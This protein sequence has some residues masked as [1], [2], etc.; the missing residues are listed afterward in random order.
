MSQHNLENATIDVN[1]EEGVHRI[2]TV[3][4]PNLVLDDEITVVSSQNLLILTLSG[5]DT[6]TFVGPCDMV[7]FAQTKGVPALKR[8][9]RTELDDQNVN[10]M[11]DKLDF[12]IALYSRVEKPR[13]TFPVSTLK[14][15]TKRRVNT[16]K[17]VS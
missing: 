8:Y 16:L 11:L 9:L 6:L 2:F 12:A 5:G 4:T 15:Q 13:A 1:I 7:N 14:R 17:S 3:C 10:L